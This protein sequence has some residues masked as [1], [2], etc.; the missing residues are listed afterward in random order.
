MMPT[1]TSPLAIRGSHA[2]FC[3]S[4]PPA[5]SARVRISGRV[6]SEPP[7]PSEPARQL[8]GRDDHADVVGLAAGRE[9]VV[10]LG[11][12]EAEP[13]E[14]GEAGDDVLGHVGVRAVHVLGDGPDLVLGEAAERLGDELEV[15]GEVRRAGAV[16]HALVGERFEERGRPVLGDER[17]R[18]GEGVARRRPTPAR[19]RAARVA[20]SCD[21]VGD[22]RAGE[23]RLDLAVLAVRAHDA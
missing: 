3:S 1:I 7:M 9:P 11:H 22:V 23:H 21:R 14:L 4:V 15:V 19:G 12:R 17:H 10:L 5:T 20:T 2:C 16:L 13:A 6:T 8:L 18:A